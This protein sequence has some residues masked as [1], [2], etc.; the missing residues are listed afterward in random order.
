MFRG[1]LVKNLKTWCNN[2]TVLNST[3]ESLSTST[4]IIVPFITVLSANLMCP[5][6]VSPRDKR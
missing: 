6:V 2:V 3:S 4:T 1:F 5:C